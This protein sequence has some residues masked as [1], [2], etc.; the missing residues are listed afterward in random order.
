[1]KRW[2]SFL[3]YFFWWDCPSID[4]YWSKKLLY[5]NLDFG[6]VMPRNQFQA[7]L[8]FLHFHDNAG[9]PGCHDPSYNHLYKIRSVTDHLHER[10]QAVY[11]PCQAVCVDESLLLW[12]VRLISRQYIPLKRA[13][14]GIK[15]YLCCESNNG[16][17]VS[18]GY[19]YR[20]KVY[21]GKEDLVNE[22]LPVLPSDAQILSTSE[23]MV[24]SLIAPLLGKGYQVY[25]DNWYRLQMYLLQKRTLACRTVRANRGVPAELEAMQLGPGASH[26][27]WWPTGGTTVPQY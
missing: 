19:C 24:L 1:M 4:L 21:A 27:M 25:T 16:K 8:R 10:F 14:F 2:R 26:A 23:R 17:K 9:M 15:L 7:I 12:K 13:R 3:G 18:S 5:R 22:I 11:E 6:S 20:F